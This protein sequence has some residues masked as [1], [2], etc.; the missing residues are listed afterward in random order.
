[1]NSEKPLTNQ[2]H[3]RFA[4]LI[5][6][7]RSATAAYTEAGYSPN[8]AEASASTL[9]RKPKVA[10]RIQHL[11]QQAAQRTVI[12]AEWVLERLRLEAE[13][14]G[15]DTSSGART[16]ATELLGKYL[17]MWNDKQEH[18]GDIRIRIIRE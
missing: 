16:K 18:T 15:P 12:T 10:E 14:L 4:R 2:R 3:E 7:G 11:K 17:T 6:E 1:M 9:L 13:G 8:G 5:A